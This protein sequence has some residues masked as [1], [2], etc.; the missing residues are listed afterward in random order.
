M[1]RHPL[2]T[3]LSPVSLLTLHVSWSTTVG[4]QCVAAVLD[5]FPITK[6]LL[7]HSVEH[8]T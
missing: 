2:Q 3:H 1:S 4:S 6:P 7:S 5:T 8:A